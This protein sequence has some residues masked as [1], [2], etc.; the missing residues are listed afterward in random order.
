MQA[1]D[2]EEEEEACGRAGIMIL[3][4]TPVRSPQLS[5]MQVRGMMKQDGAHSTGRQALDGIPGDVLV[6]AGRSWFT[7]VRRRTRVGFAAVAL[8]AVFW[9]CDMGSAL[10]GT[11]VA[12]Q[13]LRHLQV[14]F[15]R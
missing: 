10:I 7:L 9:S 4:R 8:H 12:M 11:G 14:I 6:H 1:L 15:S 2:Q 3:V 13:G 5:L